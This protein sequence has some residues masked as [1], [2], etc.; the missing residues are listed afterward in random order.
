MAETV[1]Y[2]FGMAKILDGNTVITLQNEQFGT[3]VYESHEVVISSRTKGF[4]FDLNITNATQSSKPWAYA[5]VETPQKPTVD[6]KHQ[7]LVQQH[8]EVMLDVLKQVESTRLNAAIRREKLEAELADKERADR[9][10]LRF[11]IHNATQ[12][13]VLQEE[14]IEH[15]RDD[16]ANYVAEMYDRVYKETDLDISP[17]VQKD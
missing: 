3:T 16:H 8:T 15:M 7:E 9:V 10:M 14:V 11:A 13:G 6:E 5:K 4:T 1:G 17:A 12:A 2:G